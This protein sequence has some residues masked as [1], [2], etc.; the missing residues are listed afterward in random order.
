[1]KDKPSFSGPH[2]T[3]P[4]IAATATV[5]AIGGLTGLV[6]V[7]ALKQDDALATVA[8]SLAIITFVTQILVFI[9]QTWTTSQ[10]NAETRGFLEQ[11]KTSTHGTEKAV[12]TQV[13]KLTNHLISTF[14]SLRKRDYGSGDS[15]LRESVREEVADVLSSTQNVSI[16][17]VSGSSVASISS[18]N[19]RVIDE[20]LSW[21][22]EEE[23][24]EYLRLLR[25]LS[26]IAVANI[27]MLADDELRSRQAGTEPGLPVAADHPFSE[28]IIGAGLA[29]YVP[30]PENPTDQW[31]RLT[32]MGRQVARL[33]MGAENPPGWLRDGGS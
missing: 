30:S 13:D 26:P 24:Q 25:T 21:P 1:M 4:Q 10:L 20:L 2:I 17:T 11:L 7:A 3:W 29:E 19:E 31:V 23:G 16:Q 8:L 12:N 18:A 33:M 27:R 28:E 32:N 14:E 6:I 5:L 9:A 22:N 15:D